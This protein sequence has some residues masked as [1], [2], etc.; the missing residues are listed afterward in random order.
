MYMYPQPDPRV[1]LLS[2]GRLDVYISEEVLLLIRENGKL[3]K[4]FGNSAAL[5]RHKAYRPS[6]WERRIPA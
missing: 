1:E 2:T 5:P 4:G 3:A 6:S